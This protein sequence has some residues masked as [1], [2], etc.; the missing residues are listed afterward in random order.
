VN[1]QGAHRPFIFEADH[2]KEVVIGRYDP[3]TGESPD[4]DLHEYNAYENGV[5]RQHAA[6]VWR[7]GALNLIDKGTPNGTYLNG[8]RLTPQQPHLLR[9]LDSIRVG[10]LVLEVRLTYPVVKKTHLS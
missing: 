6:I 9:D 3:D 4:V 10:R 7:N 5:S 1:V 2:I 8:R